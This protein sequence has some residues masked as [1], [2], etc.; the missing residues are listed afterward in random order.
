M[1]TIKKKIFQ[2]ISLKQIWFSFYNHPI[3]L[4]DWNTMRNLLDLKVVLIFRFDHFVNKHW[5]CI[6]IYCKFYWWIHML[7]YLEAYF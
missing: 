5:I 2:V 4:N 1:F 3:L 7:N 6:G